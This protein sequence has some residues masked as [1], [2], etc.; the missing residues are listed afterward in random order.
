MTAWRIVIGAVLA[1]A[2]AEIASADR[3]E[4]RTLRLDAKAR[5]FFIHTPDRTPR[6][7]N[8]PLMLVLHGGGAASAEGLRESYGFRPLVERGE[9]I[10]V[11]PSAFNKAWAMGGAPTADRRNPRPDHDDVAF[12]DA[13]IDAVIA[14]HPIDT[15]RLYVSGASRGGSMTQWYAPRSRYRFAGAGTVITSMVRS[16]GEGFSLPQPLTWVM[17]IG[18][19]DP[20]MPYEGRSA[21]Q[22]RDDMLA[23]DEIVTLLN[24]ANGV[25]G[26]PSLTAVLGDPD[27]RR[28]CGNELREWRD[29]GS[30][31]VTAVVRLYGGSHVMPGSWQ[32]KDFNHA[33]AMWRYFAAAAPRPQ[34]AGA[35]RPPPP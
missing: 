27:G 8:L 14:E 23:V 35:Q 10:A 34:P 25:S 9:F 5:E 30:G 24:R 2:F 20:F 26:P 7:A 18:D 4:R 15:S 29:A 3:Y 13:V 11:Y 16:I 32:C 33:E 12:L 6:G 28:S 1:A 17:M 22:R 21:D 19:K 31:A